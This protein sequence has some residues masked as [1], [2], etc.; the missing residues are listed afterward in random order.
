MAISDQTTKRK[1]RGR[2]GVP[3]HWW[4]PAS[5]LTAA[6]RH[7][8]RLK[9]CAERRIDQ[10]WGGRDDKA[11]EERPRVEKK[12]AFVVDFP[13]GGL[14]AR[15]VDAESERE[16]GRVPAVRV[17]PEHRCAVYGED[18]VGVG[19]GLLGERQNNLA[20]VRA[21][22]FSGRAFPAC[23]TNRAGIKARRASDGGCRANSKSKNTTAAA[24]GGIS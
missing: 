6:T 1:T 13:F 3:R 16:D 24:G 7:S 22:G 14:D 20:D 5:S 18:E 23:K 4:S 17:V 2:A 12:G 19:A 8:L 11:G 21:V 15:A 9:R 10:K